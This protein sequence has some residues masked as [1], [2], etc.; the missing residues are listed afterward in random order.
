MDSIQI[1]MKVLDDSTVRKVI[2]EGAD[3]ARY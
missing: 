2:E 1:K 3:K